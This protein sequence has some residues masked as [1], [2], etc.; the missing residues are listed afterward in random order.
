MANEEVRGFNIELSLDHAGVDKGLKDLQR[1][2]KITNSEFDKNLSAFQRGEESMERYETTV[3]GLNKK[4]N[5]QQ[6]IVEESRRK[7]GALNTAY[8]R[9]RPSTEQS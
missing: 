3:E 1:Q 2:M 7:L 6:N 8:D 4:M 9:Q 5:V